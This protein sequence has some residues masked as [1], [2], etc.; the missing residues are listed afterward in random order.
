VGDA[1]G[2]GDGDGD[3]LAGAVGDDGAGDGLLFREGLD[4]IVDAVGAELARTTD[5]KA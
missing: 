4:R 2:V 3:G 5:G 1:L